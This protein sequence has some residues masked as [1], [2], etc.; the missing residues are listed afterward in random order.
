MSRAS[1]PGAATIF[2]AALS[3]GPG[4]AHGA[5]SV[6]DLLTGRWYAT[7]IIV[8]ER[9]EVLDF[10]T[11]EVLVINRPRR[12]P[13]ALQVFAP[14]DG[15]YGSF[16]DIDPLTRLCLTYPVIEYT[17][18]PRPGSEPMAGAAEGVVLLDE[19]VPA[20]PAP[21]IEPRL[22]PNPH[23]ELLA[24]LADFEQTLTDRS[25]RW[26]PA[27]EHVLGR[28]ARLL[29]RRGAG[30]LLLHG[31]WLQNVPPREAPESLLLRAGTQTSRGW[32]LD[33]HVSVTLGR[34]LHFRAE[35][36][37]QAPGLGLEPAEVLLDG[38]GGYALQES[39]LPASGYML[40]SESRRMRSEEM[41]YL[42]HPK[43]GVIVLIEPV[44]VPEHLVSA[45]ESLSALEETQ[46]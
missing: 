40:L 44:P 45:F 31:R 10:N 1:L 18:S 24:A 23:L 39:V 21:S 27:S 26:L 22:E 30:R 5:E 12:L 25:S 19:H 28:E 13:Y 14:A 32:E 2:A 3:L 7:E 6:E 29:E 15:D 20:L 16:Y 35:L 8:F 37:Y 4:I 36:A 34:Y 38:E 11:R 43:L 33:G 42:D 17:T 9:S 46:Q 41:H